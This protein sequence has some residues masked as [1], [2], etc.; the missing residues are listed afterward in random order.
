MLVLTRVVN[1]LKRDNFVG[2]LGFSF[3]NRSD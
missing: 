2:L 1:M 3:R